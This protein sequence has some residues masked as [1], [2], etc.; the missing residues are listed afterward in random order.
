MT[1]VERAEY[2]ISTGQLNIQKVPIRRRI[3]WQM[4]C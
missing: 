4:V 3:G 1:S 2:G